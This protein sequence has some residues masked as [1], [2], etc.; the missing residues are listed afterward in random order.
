ME[1]RPPS[2]S[3]RIALSAVVPVVVFALIEFV[4][5]TLGIAPPPPS[6]LSVWKPEDE[7]VIRFYPDTFR[8]SPRWLWEPTPG[9]LAEGERINEDGYRGP[10]YPR[11]R[12]G[13][14]RI[15]TMGD[16]TTFGFGV[17]EGDCFSRR[18]ERI[19]AARGIDAE[20]LNFGVVGFSAAQGAVYYTGRVREY[21]PDVVIAAFG[22]VNDSFVMSQGM[23]DSDKLFRLSRPE[24][25][26]A[27]FLER[28][29]T[30]RWLRSILRPPPAETAPSG[31]VGPVG[32]A[33]ATGVTTD[34]S[35][36][37]TRS[38]VSIPEFKGALASLAASVKSDGA[39]LLLVSPPRRQDCEVTL[40]ATL[41]YT[42]AIFATANAIGVPTADVRIAFREREAALAKEAQATP[43]QPFHP[44]RSPLFIDPYHP[45]P[46]GHELYATRL[47]DELARLGWLKRG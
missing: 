31:E 9:A 22:A 10:L 27:Q 28:Y 34:G 39:R 47:A 4:I 23:G 20:V 12:G 35:G 16:S 3:L 45:S 46:L 5:V 11:E 33:P 44:E 14:L 19:L 37:L 29:S 2:V 15:A 8:T 32:S 26:I 38:R 1:Q 17:K 42:A 7:A 24:A 36:S 25:R 18:L 40:P 13:R 30:V 43:D 21:R 41:D 6:G